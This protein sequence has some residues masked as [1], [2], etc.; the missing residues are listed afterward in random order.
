MKNK[1]LCTSQTYAN[2]CIFAN[3]VVICN[4]VARRIRHAYIVEFLIAAGIIGI[5]FFFFNRI[6]D[7]TFSTIVEI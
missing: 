4:S 5:T 2:A 6:S 1:S 3:K 7:A